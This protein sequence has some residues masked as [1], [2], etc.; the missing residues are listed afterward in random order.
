[1]QQEWKKPQNYKES[2]PMANHGLDKIFQTTFLQG[3]NYPAM[4]RKVNIGDRVRVDLRDIVNSD[5]MLSPLRGMYR[6]TFASFF[7][8]DLNI[9]GWKR[10]N[11]Q[12]ELTEQLESKNYTF[13][14]PLRPN[15]STLFKWEDGSF[16]SHVVLPNLYDSRFGG[17]YR[18]KPY[19]NLTTSSE[20]LQA[21]K[22]LLVTEWVESNNLSGVGRGS[23][24]DFLGFPAGF[25]GVAPDDGE[26]YSTAESAVF[27]A[28]S[29]LHYLDIMRSC[30]TNTQTV[31][32]GISSFIPYQSVIESSSNSR[33][34]VSYNLSSGRSFYTNLTLKE[35][36]A[37]FKW[38]RTKDSDA[39][40]FDFNR[41]YKAMLNLYL[42][43][44]PNESEDDNRFSFAYYMDNNINPFSID[45]VNVTKN[46]EDLH[47]LFFFCRFVWTAL[48]PHCGLF[49]AQYRPDVYRNLLKFGENVA[50]KISTTSGSITIETIRYKNRWQQIIERFDV[51]GGRFTTAM[52]TQNGISTRQDLAVPEMLGAVTHMIDP[53]T[54]TAL[55]QT[56]EVGAPGSTD[57]G[58][59]SSNVDS[60][61]KHGRISFVAKTPGY[62]FVIFQLVPMVSYCQGIDPELRMK[63]FADD[64]NPQ[65]TDLGF[66][67]V[68]MSNY[69]ALPVTETHP[70]YAIDEIPV[71]APIWRS[72]GYAPLSEVLGRNILWSRFMTSVNSCHGEYS[73]CGNR[74][75]WVNQ[76]RFTRYYSNVVDGLNP[77]GQTVDFAPFVDGFL[78]GG[79]KQP[80]SQVVLSAN[81]VVSPY[82]DYMDYQ[83]HFKDQDPYS[84]H[85]YLDLMIDYQVKSQVPKTYM[86]QLER[87]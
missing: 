26:I 33:Y 85:W 42:G 22:D 43:S 79:Y 23:L 72:P 60:F 36:D 52:R 19:V 24:L 87:Y 67:S 68:P 62:F 10:D 6:L 41:L 8:S 3:K 58:Q 83:Y 4:A 64:F 46:T 57:V 5:P 76:R 7:C 28:D 15:S 77:E 25:Q 63:R 49:S 69:S 20:L 34:G 12:L 56:G 39:F 45:T 75:Y 80:N 50:S 59:M 78:E 35:L 32:S 29:I 55:A 13:N 53:Q 18:P 65:L 81:T 70:I 27:K 2:V 37:F 66:E 1:M 21:E 86:G 30:Y 48:K 82:V 17:P 44:Y 11:D 84:A 38:L 9:Y 54:I 71:V 73:T 74:D 14:L 16:T 61:S 31:T 51:S 47:W 40:F